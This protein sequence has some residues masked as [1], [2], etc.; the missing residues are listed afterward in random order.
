M[1]DGRFTPTV[2]THPNELGDTVCHFFYRGQWHPSPALIQQ[3]AKRVR[4]Q[5]DTFMDN[6]RAHKRF[7]RHKPDV[8]V[9]AQMGDITANSRTVKQIA[10]ACIRQ[11]MDDVNTA[12]EYFNTAY[13]PT[14]E[15]KCVNENNY[16]R[17]HRHAVIMRRLVQAIGWIVADGDSFDRMFGLSFSECCIA[18]HCDPRK[19]REQL[20]IEF[21]PLPEN[22]IR[23]L[24]NLIES[25]IDSENEL[26]VL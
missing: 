19:V 9:R 21:G 16:Q 26:C 13:H 4:Q 14:D 12:I 10:C 23:C 18:R 20:F 11:A 7:K 15:I 6:E 8:S 3:R 24:R 25:E 2:Q 5:Q 1:R 17:Q 22:M